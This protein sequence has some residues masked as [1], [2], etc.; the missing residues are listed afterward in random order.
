M[1]E[2][3]EVGTAR[4]FTFSDFSDLAAA[5]KKSRVGSI[6]ASA[7]L[8]DDAR[9]GRSCLR[10]DLGRAIAV[11]ASAQ[12]E[13]DDQRTIAA[14][15]SLEHSQNELRGPTALEQT[16]LRLTLAPLVLAFAEVKPPC[17]RSPLAVR[18]CTISGRGMG[19]SRCRGAREHFEIGAPISS[20]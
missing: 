12:G 18:P 1:V 5:G 11:V 2:D 14:V 8:A 19:P 9:A 15:R 10:F 6:P 3:D 13:R 16:P 17:P 4:G 7:N 20:D